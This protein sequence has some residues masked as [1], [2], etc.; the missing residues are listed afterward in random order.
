M[1]SRLFTLKTESTD[2][3]DSTLNHAWPRNMY[4]PVLRGMTEMVRNG[5]KDRAKSSE[6][7]PVIVF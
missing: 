2:S 6:K 1:E 7:M 4:I 3:K 5:R